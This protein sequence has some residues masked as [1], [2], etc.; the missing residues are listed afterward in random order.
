MS[1]TDKQDTEMQNT[2]KTG[3]TNTEEGKKN[4]DSSTNIVIS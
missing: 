4:D 2:E 3:D 1:E